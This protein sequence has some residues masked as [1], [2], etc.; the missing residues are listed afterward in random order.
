MPTCPGC[1]SV[2]VD[3]E[4]T[5]PNRFSV[6]IIIYHCRDCGL[7]EK[8]ETGKEYVIKDKIGQSNFQQRVDTH[9]RLDD[10]L[11]KKWGNP[12]A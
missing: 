2:N 4:D 5:P 3:Y 6:G 9:Y 11:R 12:R 8:E 10:I 1:K 7:T